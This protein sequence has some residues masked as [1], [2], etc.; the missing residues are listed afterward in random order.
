MRL[1]LLILLF[2]N[3]TSI[4]DADNI[5]SVVQI[6]DLYSRK[7]IT[8]P[9]LANL[10]TEIKFPVNYSTGTV[11]IKIPLY[12]VN[13]GSLE[14][15]IYLTYNT[16][17]IKVNDAPGWPGQGWTLHAEPTI[18][19]NFMGHIDSGLKFHFDLK[20]IRDYASKGV[21]MHDILSNNIYS[22]E[23]S[24]P[25]QFYYSLP[26][27]SGMF[28]YARKP[29]STYDYISQPFNDVK[30][31]LSNT[32]IPYFIMRDNKGNIYNFDF[33]SDF[34]SDTN[35]PFFNGW[36]TSKIESADGVDSICF[37]YNDYSSGF[38][39]QN[40]VNSISIL[41][42][43]D[44][45]TGNLY[46][47][48]SYMDAYT[49]QE[50][51]SEDDKRS[52]PIEWLMKHPCI[53]EVAD[54]NVNYLQI[55]D[56]QT[57]FDH[58]IAN[59]GYIHN[60]ETTTCHLKSINYN[61]NKIDFISN[62]ENQGRVTSIKITNSLGDVIKEIHFNYISKS[63]YQYRN[64][65]G[66]I[67]L[68]SGNDSVSYTFTYNNHLQIPD[69]GDMNQD[70]W[71][72]FNGN[73]HPYRSNNSL[74]PRIKVMYHQNTYDDVPEDS[75]YIGSDNMYNGATD[76]IQIERGSLTSITYP[77]GVT[78]KFTYEPN[79]VRLR[80]PQIT[81]NDVD[82]HMSDHLY[83]V[84]G[85][86]NIYYVGGLRIK[87]I[88]SLTKDGTCNIRTFKYNDDGAGTSPIN[89][90][91]DYFVTEKKEWMPE[92]YYGYEGAIRDI[93]F[94][95][96]TNR[97]Y[98]SKP[99][100]PFTY[101]NGSSVMYEKVTEYDG[102]PDD[103]KGYTVYKY[104]VPSNNYV[105]GVNG[106]YYNDL[107]TYFD[108]HIYDLQ[109]YGN[110]LTKQIFKK[111]DNGSYELVED[112]FNKYNNSGDSKI[113]KIVMGQYFASS[114]LDA[115]YQ[116][117]LEHHG[118]LNEFDRP[119][120]LNSFYDGGITEHPIVKNYL[121][122]SVVTQL[123]KDHSTISTTTSYCYGNLLEMSPTEKETSRDASA[124]DK[125]YCK[126]S[127]LYP[128][129]YDA[130]IFKD[131]VSR[132]ILSIPISTKDIV[133]NNQSDIE[134]TISAES[135]Y[136]NVNKG[137]KIPVY[138]EISTAYSYPGNNHTE[139]RMS[140]LY[141]TRGQ[142]IQAQ[143]DNNE[144]ESYLYGYNNQYIIGEIENASFSNIKS[145]LGE[146][147]IN[148]VANASSPDTYAKQLL[149]KLTGMNN[150]LANFYFYKPL[151][152]VQKVIS[153]DGSGILYNYDD[154]GRLSGKS[155]LEDNFSSPQ[156]LEKYMYHYKT[157]K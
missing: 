91:Y 105:S 70:F 18:A 149:S 156:S 23:D 95:K 124:Y 129:N 104:N 123:L 132:N 83:E 136:D 85:K 55:Q 106:T 153:P 139:T 147:L 110:L 126:E 78:D 43:F 112:V 30:V 50:K 20:K 27:T 45:D 48:N 119:S 11:D 120:C 53:K 130:P 67:S 4:A 151:V 108:E 121:T 9:D 33:V 3:I 113:G 144:V 150:T 13:C 1:F 77:T 98:Y 128:S 35:G 152:G 60:I 12:T 133:K 56:D 59:E 17:G 117:L 40:H 142:L 7:K 64:F 96:C 29:D 137:G 61:G 135:N 38:S 72:Y 118:F 8:S 69:C 31:S 88:S 47:A 103:N 99:V 89:N 14:L 134:M 97:T 39:C 101:S 73:N 74:V 114:Q 127:Y 15:P 86:E 57:V 58:S 46:N 36:K 41:K 116:F 34:R 143:K 71:G 111:S 10:I 62:K 92:I 80:E 44:D 49:E 52:V 5:N 90:D 138:R 6:Q 141:N 145:V 42:N 154:F 82:F 51:I 25:D 79:Q 54:Y 102:T 84:P 76:S 75:F 131:M 28:V 100:I 81:N 155:F 109:Y 26:N 140:Y 87:Q 107:N 24:Q 68:I 146:S 19:R 148:E 115:D 63:N 125:E 94:K 37:S 2:C 65:L 32:K 122:S 93:D 66:S 157:S 16:A 22:I 21:Y